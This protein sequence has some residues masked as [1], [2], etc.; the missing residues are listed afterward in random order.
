MHAGYHFLPCPRKFPQADFQ[1]CAS[2]QICN[3][4]SRKKLVLA[5]QWSGES[6]PEK[7]NTPEW[8]EKLMVDVSRAFKARSR[9]ERAILDRIDDIDVPAQ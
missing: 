1:S 4:L 7:V 8:L 9:D 2:Q 5:G 6:R 3:S